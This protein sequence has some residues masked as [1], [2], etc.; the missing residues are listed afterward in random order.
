MSQNEEKSLG[1]LDKIK[2]L[3]KQ[4]HR[5][6]K[7]IAIYTHSG[8]DPDAISS[9][10]AMQ[11]LF[12]HLFGIE[13]DCFYVGE[14]SHPQNKAMVQ[15]LDVHLIKA[16][17][18]GFKRRDADYCMNVLVDTIPANAGEPNR[19]NRTE[20]KDKKE[21]ESDEPLQFDLVIDHHKVLP[22]GDFNGL[23]VHYH[24]GSNAGIVYELI[25]S[26]GIPLSDENEHWV[27]IANGLLVG[28]IT[29][30]DHCMAP[31]TTRR[32]FFARQELFEYQDHDLIRKIVKFSRPMSWVRLRGMAIN[33]FVIDEG[34]AVVGLGF[35]PDEQRDVIADIATDMLSWGNVQTAVVFAMFGDRIEGSVRTNNEAVEI[36]ALCDQ[37]GGRYGCGGGKL[38]KGAFRKPLAGMSLDDDEDEAIRTQFWDVIKSREIAKILKI[39]KQ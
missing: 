36:H 3:V 38:C 39:M 26:S 28:I 8:P 11:Y 6:N 2:A 21:K 15:L 5:E 20:K 24:T 14:I 32:D 4:K 23:L 27:K 17:A 31:D 35:L 16:D 9:M 25:R 18:E 30:T 29:D 12:Q 19:L 13:S 33:D 10:M 37:L 7:K 34:V 22:N 1:D